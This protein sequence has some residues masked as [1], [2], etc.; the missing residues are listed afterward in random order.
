M[1]MKSGRY[2]KGWFLQRGGVS[3]TGVCYHR[4]YLVLFFQNQLLYLNILACFWN[5]FCWILIE[6]ERITK[7]PLNL[8]K[9]REGLCVRAVI[10]VSGTDWCIIPVWWKSSYDSNLKKILVLILKESRIKLRK[11]KEKIQCI[12]ML[13]KKIARLQNA[14]LSTSHRLLRCQVVLTKRL[15]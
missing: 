4:V 3:T 1:T 9:S 12:A 5:D 7:T 13:L 14:A 8:P 10:G 15:F 2:A 6:N 11:K